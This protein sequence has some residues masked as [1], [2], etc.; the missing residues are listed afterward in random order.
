[1]SVVEE[2]PRTAVKQFDPHSVRRDFPILSTT[3]DGR[4]LVYLDNGA[5]TQ[6]P[7]AVIDAVAH[8]YEAQN[9][10]IHRGVYKLSIEATEMYE[11]TR[12]KVRRFIN[13]AEDREIIYTRGTT[14]S[15]NLD[16]NSYGRLRL[17][18]S[19]EV[20]ISAMEHHSNIVPWQMVCEATG[21]K[22]RVIPMNDRGELLIDEYEKILRGGRVKLISIVH[23]SNSLGTINDV[24]TITEMAHAAGAK[25]MV[26]GAQWVAHHTTD[27]R[28]IGC[29]FYAFSGH[30]LFGPTGIGVLYGKREL[31]EAMPPWQGGG[32]MI[33][34]V[35][36]EKTT[37]AD[38]P[39][40]FEAGTP[41][42]AGVAGLG[43]AI[44][45]VS[46]IGLEKIAAYEQ[47]LLSYAHAHL[48]DVPGL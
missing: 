42:I 19:D 38:L 30:K 20:V 1:M 31:L 37:Y 15:I 13:A 25:V 3:V 41:H 21:A 23:L 4:P 26:D 5:T 44:D 8:Y 14:E 7:R 27:V 34:S 22:L 18:A 10:N 40:K 28:D 35:T 11:Q 29:D 6:K 48:T 2:Q 16:A 32:D 43:A 33:N 36:F 39:A 12:H 9:A 46:K 24:K 45:Y 47:E 17:S